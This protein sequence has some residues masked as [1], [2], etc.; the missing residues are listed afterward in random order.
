MSPLQMQD[1]FGNMTW[2]KE[3]HYLIMSRHFLMV[4]ACQKS[5][6]HPFYM[7]LVKIKKLQKRTHYAYIAL[8]LLLQLRTKQRKFFLTHKNRG[9]LFKATQGAVSIC[10]ETEKC[11]QRTKNV[12][13][14]NFPRC[15]CKLCYS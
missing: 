7:K 14:Q 15:C 10:E 8:R 1:F 12:T 5:R 6:R 3:Y 4:G 13:S 11:F 2:Q 9:S